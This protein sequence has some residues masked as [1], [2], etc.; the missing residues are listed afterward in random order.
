M[1]HRYYQF[2]LRSNTFIINSKIDNDFY[3]SNRD[4]IIIFSNISLTNISIDDIF[5][6]TE[7]D[8]LE[9]DIFGQ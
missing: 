4:K 9:V 1:N 5:N 7:G 8:I 6:I 3:P 2:L